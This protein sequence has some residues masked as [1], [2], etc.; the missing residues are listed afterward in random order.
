MIADFLVSF[1]SVAAALLFVEAFRILRRL[2]L[3][4]E[5][6]KYRPHNAAIDQL[7]AHPRHERSAALAP[8]KTQGAF[9]DAC[10]IQNPSVQSRSSPSTGTQTKFIPVHKGVDEVR[11]LLES[12]SPRNSITRRCENSFPFGREN[13]QSKRDHKQVSRPPLTG[14]NLGLVSAKG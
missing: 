9:T 10:D 8:I 1:V 3:V 5:D 12:E 13:A 2:G 4:L 7:S 11:H 14:C 6:S